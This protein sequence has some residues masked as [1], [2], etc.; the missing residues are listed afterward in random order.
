MKDTTCFPERSLHTEADFTR[1]TERTKS[2]ED[3]IVKFTLY[4]PVEFEYWRTS[5]ITQLQSQLW[6]NKLDIGHPLS[7]LHNLYWN[8]PEMVP[9]THSFSSPSCTECYDVY[10]FDIESL[11]YLENTSGRMLVKEEYS[12]VQAKID[13]YYMV[14]VSSE[15]PTPGGVQLVAIGQSK[16]SLQLLYGTLETMKKCRPVL[17]FYLEIGYFFCAEGVFAV[18]PRIIGRDYRTVTQFREPPFTSQQKIVAFIECRDPR[19]FPPVAL[20][21]SPFFPVYA[22]T[23]TAQ[24][25]HQCEGWARNLETETIKVTPW[26]RAQLDILNQLQAPKVQGYLDSRFASLM[27]R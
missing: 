14:H 8:N 15:D 13:E 12:R 7:R 22:A 16:P 3:S 2:R 20:V 5:D 17:L 1:F 4:R 6:K 27:I 21:E 18:P 9:E 23:V 10:S 24:G 26:T 19:M 25:Y 11:P